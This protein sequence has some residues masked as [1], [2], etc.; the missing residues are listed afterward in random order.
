ML[1]DASA[2]FL[3]AAGWGTAAAQPLAGD[4]SARAYLRLI[5]PDGSRAVLML[6][7]GDA[8]TARFVTV[9]AH[10]HGIGLSVPKILAADPAA[11]LLLLED[12]GDAVFARLIET[13][14]TVERPLYM[15]AVELLAGLPSHSALAGLEIQEPDALA[16]AV[17]PAADWYL[18]QGTAQPDAAAALAAALRPAL[19]RILP[20]VQPVFVHRDFHAENLIWLPDRDG[21]AQIGLLD[22]Q[23]A[24]TGH[25]AYDLVS[26][27]EDARRDLAPD[28]RADMV[29]HYARLTGTEP[30]E[31]HRALAILGA[32]RNLRILGI[33]ARLSLLGGKPRYVDLIPRVWQHLHGDLAHPS[34]RAV[35]ET[36]ARLLPV[37]TP[38]FLSMLTARCGTIP[39]R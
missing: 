7:H 27:L 21:P 9:D 16:Q 39:T 11:G 12:L 6:A 37:P 13:D 17:A 8:S 2:G 20:A 23:D 38:Q 4:A 26:L 31:L 1:D 5:R 14:P 15:A 34:L 24:L 28:L 33:F 36:V 25:P 30:D 35:G 32:Q 22:F 3:A 29:A 10:L 19:A 18:G